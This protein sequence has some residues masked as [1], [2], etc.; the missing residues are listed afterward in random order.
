M[1]V[2][3]TRDLMG[4][5]Y[6]QGNSAVMQAFVDKQNLM[7]TILSSPKRAAMC[8]ANMYVETAG[9]NLAIVRNLTENTNYSA[10]GMAKT[11][12]K[13]FANENA[14]ISKYGTDAGWRIH[15]FDD[16]YGNRMGNRPG[17][18]D[19]S[20]Y[21]GRGG[22]QITGR[23][24]YAAVGKRIGV[25]LVV[26]PTFACK[27]ELQPAIAEAFWNW[28][29]EQAGLTHVADAGNVVRAREIWNGGHNGL[30]VVETQYP[31]MLKII[32]SHAPSTAAI[33]VQ[34][35][36]ADVDNDL[37]E[38]QNDLIGFGYHEVGNAEGRVGG[39]TVGAIKAFFIDRGVTSR[40]EY[41]GS[42]EVLIAE[43]NKAAG[44]NWHR[45]VA[46]G[47]A[48]ATEKELAPTVS[49]IAP[50]QS[51]GLLQKL[52]AWFTGTSATVGAAVKFLPDANDQAYPYWS[53]IQQFFPSVPQLL[54]FTLVAAVAIITVRQIEK[55]KKATVDDYQTGKIN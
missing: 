15:A 48:F 3:L 25:D 45:P 24:G 40:S 5:L 10:R 19:G 55:S 21:I 29:N 50:A 53:M 1:A 23:D 20:N 7:P 33:N 4:K 43:L 30:E 27:P 36:T 12:P 47:R 13:R 8:F 31:R 51:A 38:I 41:P 39:R 9:F 32:E 18:H 49:S 2:I 54:F 16:I 6:P 52:T 44:E 35:P 34:S 28:K 46:P 17:T 37:I 22:P 42:K 26:N 14:V 11:W